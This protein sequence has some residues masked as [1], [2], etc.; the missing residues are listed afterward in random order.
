[1][2]TQHA[3]ADLRVELVKT[4]ES[5][6]TAD[7]ATLKAVRKRPIGSARASVLLVHGLGQNRY[8]FHLDKL[9]FTAWLVSQGYD[10]WNL[11]LRGHGRSRKGNPRPQSADDYMQLDFPAAVRTIRKSTDHPVF[12]LGHSIGGAVVYGGAPYVRDLLAGVVGVAPVYAFGGRQPLFAFVGRIL[13]RLPKSR[14]VN[15]QPVPVKLAAKLVLGGLPVIEHPMMRKSPFTL[16]EPRSLPKEVLEFRVSEGFDHL[17]VGVLRHLMQWATTREFVS[18]DGR[19][20]YSQRWSQLGDVPLLVVAGSRD[21]LLPPS[22]AK[23]GFSRSPSTDKTFRVFG[24]EDGGHHWGHVDL[25][26][27]KK[28]PGLVWPEIER[29]LRARS[30]REGPSDGSR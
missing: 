9:S 22:D 19:V 15:L 16:W 21:T 25:I 24:R 3:L 6:E 1:M 26:Q 20:D 29:W 8:T 5:I 10:T 28:A 23:V 11:D 4:V 30:S 13:S 12:A 7:G 18:L 17:T 27:G 2:E 14:R